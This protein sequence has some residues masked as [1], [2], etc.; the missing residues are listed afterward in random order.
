MVALEVF[1]DDPRL[2]YSGYVDVVINS[3]AA[4]FSRQY[5]DG[6]LDGFGPAARQAGGARVTFLT[7]ATQIAVYFRYTAP[8]DES[9]SLNLDGRSCYR[10]KGCDGCHGRCRNEC[11]LSLLL[12][13]ESLQ[14][15]ALQQSV[16]DAP[17]DRLRVDLPRAPMQD[18]PREYTLVMPWGAAVQFL[19][20]E[21]ADDRATPP[22]LLLPA[23]AGRRVRYVAYGDSITHGFCGGSHSYPEQLARLNG[24]EC[25]NMGIQGLPAGSGARWDHGAAIAERAPQLVTILIGINDCFAHDGR[26]EPEVGASVGSIVDG[27]RKTIPSVPIAVLTPIVTSGGFEGWRAGVEQLR[28]Q[29]RSAVAMRVESGDRSLHLVEGLPL[30]PASL[31]FE[32]LHPNT[33]GYAA[34]ATSLNAAMGFSRVAFEVRGC[35]PLKLFLHGLTPGGRYAVYYSPTTPVVSARYASTAA[36]PCAASAV[37]F[38]YVAS[39]AADA[40]ADGTAT[41]TLP[42][43]LHCGRAA[44]QVLDLASCLTSRV[45]TDRAS[46]GAKGTVAEQMGRSSF[47]PSPP[48][49]P[50][51]PIPR[52]SPS[53]S[54]SPS[55]SSSSSSSSSATATSISSQSSPP[56]SS[57]S[58]SS[59]SSSPPSGAPHSLAPRSSTAPTLPS[60][61]THLHASTAVAS[62]AVSPDSTPSLR[63]SQRGSSASSPFDSFDGAVDTVLTPVLAGLVFGILIVAVAS[64][65]QRCL[66]SQAVLRPIWRGISRGVSRR[67]S[68]A[69]RRVGD[70]FNCRRRESSTSILPAALDLSH[71]V[72]CAA[73]GARCQSGLTSDRSSDSGW[74]LALCVHRLDEDAATAQEDDLEIEAPRIRSVGELRKIIHDALTR[75]YGDVAVR[76]GLKLLY[77]TG[78][79]L[80]TLSAKVPLE[81]ALARQPLH[82][83]F[84]DRRPGRMQ[85]LLSAIGVSARADQPA[86]AQNQRCGSVENR[87]SGHNSPGGHTDPNS[88]KSSRSSSSCSSHNGTHNSGSNSGRSNTLGS[89]HS[90][91]SGTGPGCNRASRKQCV[92]A[93][94]HAPMLSDDELDAL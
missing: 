72:S 20:L 1:P 62:A 59:S 41:H 54:T 37:M 26:P 51:P 13:G 25:V 10:H 74:R 3:E 48:P 73:R 30:V 88:R 61:H 53:P 55:T 17:G 46:D 71:G 57:T 83:L 63:D 22:P 87:R 33:E 40:D 49:S 35:S 60:S 93:R 21:L 2:V 50:P 23:A 9:C 76:R 94:E 68:R 77:E 29:I 82:V 36:P 19:G 5:G 70:C 7:T 65:L 85:Q 24:F 79:E 44:W 47:R 80:A 52:A 78:N 28:V 31:M 81:A 92:R 6:S 86:T 89:S 67:F 69:L 15:P 56:S 45:G 8:C 84:L 12:D 27:I 16:V 90:S 11:S 34:M 38:P 66:C 14:V 75:Q 42:R 58:S 91:A 39:V 4:S 43:N 18:A 64:L 32:G